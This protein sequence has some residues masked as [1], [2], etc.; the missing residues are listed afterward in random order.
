MSSNMNRRGGQNKWV[1]SFSTLALLLFSFAISAQQSSEK[2][3]LL[4]IDIMDYLPP[5]PILIDSALANAP[6]VAY[7]ESLL[8]STEYDVSLE[9]KSW[10]NDVRFQAG[11]TWTLGNQLVLQGI[12][13]GAADEVNQGY[14]YGVAISVP[15]SSWYG[16]NDRINRAEAL[17]GSQQSK[18]D[19]ASVKTIETVIETYSQLLLL[20]RLLRISSEAKES[21]Q[22]ILEMAEERFRDG[23]LSLEELSSATDYKARYA[24][25]YEQTRTQFSNAYSKLERLAGVSFSKMK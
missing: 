4:S 3:T 24:S 16:R 10:S 13:T 7:F 8:E 5:L 6:E 15:L 2:D 22:L 9:K 18:I 14:N 25:E 20:Q 19:E 1:T 23:E 11:Y 21:S 17:R 12:S